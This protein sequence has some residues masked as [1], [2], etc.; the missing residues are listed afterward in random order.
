M[1]MTYDQR[2]ADPRWTEASRLFDSGPGLDPAWAR[3]NAHSRPNIRYAVQEATMG[4]DSCYEDPDAVLERTVRRYV[5]MDAA[6]TALL[7][8][9]RRIVRSAGRPSDGA[10]R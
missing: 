7:Q 3:L 5:R 8:E 4:A 6:G 2:R 9:C 10:G 1:A